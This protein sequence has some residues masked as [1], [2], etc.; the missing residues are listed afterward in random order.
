VRA[1]IPGLRRLTR[2]AP[3]DFEQQLV[4]DLAA[5]GVA[6]VFIP[7]PKQ[8]YA[9]GAVRWLSKDRAVIQLSLRYRYADVFW[10]TFFHELGHLLLHGKRRFF[11]DTEATSA[12]RLEYEADRFA[13]S[14]L[15]RDNEY[16]P[17]VSRGDF[18]APAIIA[19]ADRIEVAPGIVVGRL[20]HDR[21]IPFS[22]H[23]ALRTK[24]KW[25]G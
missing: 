5:S 14:T 21:L 8:T 4:Q 18:T 24:F 17:F 11:V 10:F 22:W 19:F 6:V 13:A 3:A 12:D 23:A 16:D 7:H 2:L 9:N 15:I 1:A 20:Q 25:A